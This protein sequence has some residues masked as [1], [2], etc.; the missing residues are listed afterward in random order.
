MTFNTAWLD[1]LWANWAYSLFSPPP[2]FV[3]AQS[4]PIWFPMTSH[5]KHCFDPSCE[6]RITL[7]PTFSKHLE[8]NWKQLRQ[9]T[10]TN[11]GGENPKSCDSL[12]VNR[13]NV[14][15]FF[16]FFW[17]CDIK[18]TAIVGRGSCGP[19]CGCCNRRQKVHNYDN[20]QGREYLLPSTKHQ[21]FK[22]PRTKHWEFKIPQ[23]QAQGTVAQHQSPVIPK[24]QKP[25]TCRTFCNRYSH[26]N[27]NINII[28]NSLEGGWKGVDTLHRKITGAA[29]S[30]MHAAIR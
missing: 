7:P 4:T 30:T 17:C 16:Q 5:R 28:A 8:L 29:V 6:C 11:H 15:P 13:R 3:T 27:C 25:S 23:H 20:S 22:R 26:V 18:D 1:P 2:P 12:L 19:S 14:W 21:E 10:R 9:G 24:N